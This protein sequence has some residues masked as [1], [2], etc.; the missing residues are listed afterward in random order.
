[1]EEETTVWFSVRPSRNLHLGLPWRLAIFLFLFVTTAAFGERARLHLTEEE[2][3]RPV[4]RS[5]EMVVAPV[6]M[7]QPLLVEPP[8]ANAATDDWRSRLERLTIALIA[9]TA[10][11]VLVSALLL[12]H[13]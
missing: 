4:A 13:G 11:M 9:L 10:V 6:E 2:L 3:A 5:S 12:T 1:M 7:T 8:A